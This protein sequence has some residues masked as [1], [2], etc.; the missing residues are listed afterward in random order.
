LDWLPI[1]V[2]FK[3]LDL[4]QCVFGFHGFKRVEFVNAVDV[5]FF[6]V[7]KSFSDNYF[8]FDQLEIEHFTQVESK[9]R[10]DAVLLIK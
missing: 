10:V 8:S 3:F 7:H 5:K 4:S 9:A 6:G 1:L 2:A